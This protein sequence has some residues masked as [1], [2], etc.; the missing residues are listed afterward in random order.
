MSKKLKCKY[1]LHSTTEIKHS[2]GRFQADINHPSTGYFFLDSLV[3]LVQGAT[4][5]YVKLWLNLL[6]KNACSY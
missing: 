6:V 1:Y 5:V 3:A 4:S 2:N